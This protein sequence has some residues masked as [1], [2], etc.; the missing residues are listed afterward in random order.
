MVVPFGCRQLQCG[1]TGRNNRTHG[2]GAHGV[3]LGHTFIPAPVWIVVTPGG[4]PAKK[5]KTT[6]LHWRKIARWI[7]DVSSIKACFHE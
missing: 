4:L 2:I 7:V 1:K 6:Y 3:E 5:R